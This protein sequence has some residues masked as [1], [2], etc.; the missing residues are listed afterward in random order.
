MQGQLVYEP[1]INQVKL[2][3]PQRLVRGGLRSFVAAPLLVESEVFGVLIAGRR[4]AHAFS[5]GECEFLKQL[6]EHAALA[7]HQAQLYGE[8]QRAYDDLRQT[9]QATMQQERLRALGQMASGVA[10]DINNA[11][12]PVALYTEALLEKEPGV[13]ERGRAYLTTI[14]RAIEGV[15]E[16]V[17]RMREL[18]R[19]HEPQVVL[20]HVN[21]NR[22]V[23][24]VIGLTRARWSDQP[25]HRGIV[26]EVG[27]ELAAEL[28]PISGAEAEIRDALTNLIFNAVDAMPE[29]G[30]LTVRTKMLTVEGMDG[31]EVSRPCVEVSDT[32]AGMSEETRRHCLEP[33]FTTKGERGTGLGL[34]MVYGMVQ[35]HGADL[36]IESEPG[37]GTTMRL[38]FP[39]AD[40]AVAASVR[41]PELQALTRRLR[42]LV[43]DDDPIVTESLRDSLHGDGHFVTTADGG[44]AGI[45]AFIA[46]EVRGEPFAIV[47][48]DL[49]MPHIDGRKVAAAIRAASPKTPIVLLTGWG[50]RLASEHGVPAEVNRLLSKPPK[51]RELRAA[52]AELTQ[53]VSVRS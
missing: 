7:A 51:L 49:G 23:E 41:A 6:S 38:A 29:G 44:R 48:T 3:F 8:L 39:A 32:G 47:I 33:F 16:T 42:V 35:R 21:I 52:L 15:A 53:D 40:P 12:S 46:A 14:Q 1:D 36:Q 13:S 20:A 50:Q 19:P 10:H 2:P 11:L 26:I 34:A 5:S 18:Y 45:D 17:S 28:P 31:N 22:L 27:T 24:Q 30:T 4:E 9:Q 37:K 25:Q 43:V